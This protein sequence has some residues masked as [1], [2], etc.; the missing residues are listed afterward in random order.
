MQIHWQ[1]FFEDFTGNLVRFVKSQMIM[2]A[3]TFIILCIGLRQ[4]EVAL[5]GLA[6]AGIA[7]FD[8]I[9]VLGSGMIMIPWAIIRALTLS[10]KAGGQIAVLYIILVLVRTIVE[11]ILTGSKLGVNPLLL[12]L[13]SLIGAMLLGPFGAIIGALVVMAFKSYNTVMYGTQDSQQKIKS[14]R[15]RIR[16]EFDSE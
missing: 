1:A 12:F 9:P 16:S 14:K 10:P 13:A 4:F 8:L 7:L 2:L 3:L 11:P 6:A 5:W 15:D